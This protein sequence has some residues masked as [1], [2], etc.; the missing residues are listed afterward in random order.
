MI[1]PMPVYEYPSFLEQ[2]NQVKFPDNNPWLR[3]MIAGT[4]ITLAIITSVALITLS[5]QNNKPLKSNE[6]GNTNE[7]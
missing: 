7:E 1:N 6:N 4:V 2:N 5:K 3:Y